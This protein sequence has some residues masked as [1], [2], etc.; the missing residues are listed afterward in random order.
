M[1]AHYPARLDLASVSVVLRY[2][3]ALLARLGRPVVFAEEG[4]LGI[5]VF[6]GELFSSLLYRR[7]VGAAGVAGG[8]YYPPHPLVVEGLSYV[9]DYCA[10]RSRRDGDGAGVV[11]R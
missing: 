6:H 7:E 10:H 2:D 4:D 8:E 3:D 9:K 1:E 11:A 5:G